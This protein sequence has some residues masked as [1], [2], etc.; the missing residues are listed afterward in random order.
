MGRQKEVFGR[1]GF[2]LVLID[3]ALRLGL[4]GLWFSFWV[5][6]SKIVSKRADLGSWSGAN[7]RLHFKTLQRIQSVY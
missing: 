1:K 5:H 6:G 3:H 7:L 4:S 2:V